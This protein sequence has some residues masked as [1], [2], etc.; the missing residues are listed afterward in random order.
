MK[1]KR[2][3]IV[4]FFLMFF[5]LVFA[6]NQMSYLKKQKFTNSIIGISAGLYFTYNHVDDIWWG[7]QK[8][9]FTFD[10]GR[11]AVYALNVDKCGHFIGG[12]IFSDIVYS[13]MYN[14]G[15]DM[16]TSKWI[17]GFSGSVLQLA[18][19][20]KDAYSPYWGFSKGDLVAGTFGSFWP[21]FQ[22]YYEPLNAIN[23]K[24]SYWN[25]SN[26]YQNLQAEMNEESNNFS[27]QDNYINQTYWITF[28][29]KKALSSE[30]FPDWL[31]L[32]L[33]FSID[34]SQ[35]LDQYNRK[36]GGENEF[37]LSL[38]YN[39]SL[40]FKKTPNNRLLKWI[41]YFHFPAPAIRISPKFEW[42]PLFL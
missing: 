3:L 14:S 2:L 38:D 28:N 19:E 29:V 27:W 39:L 40:L 35:Y 8:T 11:D 32:A 33:G 12:L 6:Q 9:E 5:Q 26:H 30:V 41:E 21:V 37:Y 4:M 34:D 36:Q 10:S 13:S 31:N 17:G 42:Y 16:L 20:V 15:V 1:M 7:D 22:Y 18:I 24:F 23:F 25:K